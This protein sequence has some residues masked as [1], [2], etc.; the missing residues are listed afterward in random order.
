MLEACVVI[1]KNNQPIYWNLPNGRT[2]V[3]VPD[4]RPFWDVVYER[5]HEIKGIA[6]SHPGGG[7]PSP[8]YEDITTFDAMEEGLGLRLEWW[9]TSSNR[10]ISCK[11][12]GKQDYSSQEDFGVYPEWL[13]KLR[14][15][16]G[17][18]KGNEHDNSNSSISG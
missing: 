4:S 1:D 5:R 2:S 18:G 14:S 13:P 12:Q 6:H 3:K 11:W 17:Y 8:S 10:L 7:L 16:S 9:I 15:L